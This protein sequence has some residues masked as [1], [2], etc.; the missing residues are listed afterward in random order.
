MEDEDARLLQIDGLVQDHFLAYL[1]GP[2]PEEGLSP[3]MICQIV[4]YLKDNAHRMGRKD[5]HDRFD[6]LAAALNK[7]A[8][9][10]RSPLRVVEG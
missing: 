3:Q 2:P 9:N 10:L 1:Q 5:R 4:K 7:Q 8:D 6:E